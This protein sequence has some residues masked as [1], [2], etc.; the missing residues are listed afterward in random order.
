MRRTSTFV[1]LCA[2][3]LLCTPAG[4]KRNEGQATSATVPLKVWVV[5]GIG[6]GTGDRSNLGCRLTVG[7]IRQRIEH[8]QS[9]SS[10]YG[11]NTEF[12]WSPST[13]TEVFLYIEPDNR[14]VD[15]NDFF[16]QLVVFNW[17]QGRINI[18]FA[19]NVQEDR[20]VPIGFIG[21]A[22]DPQE[23]A[24]IGRSE[25][26]ILLNDGGFGDP[27]GFAV[28]PNTGLL[29]SPSNVTGANVLEHEMAHYLARFKNRMFGQAPN[30]RVYSNFEHALPGS[31]NLLRPALPFPLIIPGTSS[32]P[33][34]EKFEIWERIR[35]GQWDDP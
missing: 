6:E 24:G 30:I 9:N 16:N 4:C 19:G 34:T 23:I 20:N 11:P 31:N 12:V 8:L 14:T 13:P 29:L 17:Q 7:E 32:Q 33:N 2:L 10:L 5:L 28:D 35:T 26:F 15:L 18:Y 22:L 25:S 3:S 1:T 27:S 21:H